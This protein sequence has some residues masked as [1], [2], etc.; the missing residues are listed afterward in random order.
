MNRLAYDGAILV[1]V[2][3]PCCCRKTS[4]LKVNMYSE[5]TLRVTNR[6]PGGSGGSSRSLFRKSVVSQIYKGDPVTRGFKK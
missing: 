3:M 1:P 5:E 2:A 6:E 4:L